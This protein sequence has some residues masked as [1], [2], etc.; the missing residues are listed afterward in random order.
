M[1]VHPDQK[2]VL[3]LF[4]EASTRRDGATKNDREADASKRRLTLL[5]EAFPS[6]PSRVVEDR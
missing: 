2:P 4:P 6:W 3:P 1:I 5:G